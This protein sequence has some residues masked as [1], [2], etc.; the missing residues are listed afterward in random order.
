MF[1]GSRVLRGPS[2]CCVQWRKLGSLLGAFGFLYASVV[3][4]GVRRPPCSGSEPGRGQGAKLRTGPH[5][6]PPP[7]FHIE[8]GMHFGRALQGQPGLS[9]EPSSF[10]DIFW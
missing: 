7:P 8:K 5:P 3:L 9:Q 1:S 10:S 6:H 2:G 4:R